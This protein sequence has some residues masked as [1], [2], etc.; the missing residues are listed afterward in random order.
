MKTS[1]LAL[2]LLGALLMAACSN[3][4]DPIIIKGNEP[5]DDKGAN[6]NKNITNGNAALARLEFPK[7]KDDAD[8]VV[9]VRST[10][11]HGV[12]YSIEYNKPKRAQRWTC[13]QL[14]N[15]NSVRS[16]NR[17]NWANYA[18]TNEWVARNLRDYGFGD[19][20]QPDPDLPVGVRT[21]LEEYRNISY[22]RGHICASSDRLYSMQANEQTFYLSNIL[23]QSRGLN[24]GI[25][26]DMEAY[27]N[28]N[29]SPTWNITKFRDTLY[30][31]KGGTIN[32]GM[33]RATTATGLVV[34]KY[35]FM[36]LLCRKGNDFKALGLW[37][38]HTDQLKKD[39]VQNYV[40]NIDYLEQRTGIDFFCNLP[41]DIEEDVE[42]TTVATIKKEWFP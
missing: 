4:D 15:S 14:Y 22:Q 37:V 30:V 1:K 42:S 25:W 12:T 40:V 23:P 13:F 11:S 26:Q 29:T 32:D 33:I 19:P 2:I 27:V 21:E 31:C 41:D 8:N 35:F 7:T 3:D 17:N 24:T 38:E 20:F 18:S 28:G 10:E 36:A 34:P 5:L 16:W 9:L 39:G 6:V